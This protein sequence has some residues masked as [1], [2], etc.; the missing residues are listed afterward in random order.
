VE[1]INSEISPTTS[2]FVRNL[3]FYLTLEDE[4]NPI[5][6]VAFFDHHV[7]RLELGN[8]DV[9]GD[10]LDHFDVEILQNLDAR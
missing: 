2:P 4:V 7:A 1:L 8:F 9:F 6:H 5:A 3:D 10:I